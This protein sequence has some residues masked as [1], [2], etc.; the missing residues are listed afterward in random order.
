[1]THPQA[2]GTFDSIGDQATGFDEGASPDRRPASLTAGTVIGGKF[3]IDRL[4]G[5]GGM[6]TVYAAT[7]TLAQSSVALKILSPELTENERSQQRFLQEFRIAQQLSH[8]GVVRAYAVDRHEGQFYY[9]MELV[10][11]PSLRDE[12]RKRKEP[13]A[14]DEAVAIVRGLA[15]A[16]EHAHTITVHR[17]IKPDNVLVAQGGKPKLLDFG[18]AK[19][20]LATDV[21][22]RTSAAMGTAYYMAPEQVRGASDVDARADLYSLGV[23]LYELLTGD[24][25][26]LGALPLTEA[27]P[28][29]PPWIED[30]YRKAVAPRDRRFASARALIDALDARGAGESASSAAAASQAGG[31]G[32]LPGTST[33]PEPRPVAQVPTPLS[34]P[35]RVIGSL[36]KKPWDGRRLP[37]GASLKRPLLV[38]TAGQLHV[39]GPA[40]EMPAGVPDRGVTRSLMRPF[41]ADEHVPVHK[42]RG[43]RHVWRL[44]TWFIL[45]VLMFVGSI[46]LAAIDPLLTVGG[47]AATLIF[48]A[49]WAKTSG[50]DHLILD[51]EGRS[52]A[53][54]KA[55]VVDF[56]ALHRY[57]QFI[58]QV[59]AHIPRRVEGPGAVGSNG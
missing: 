3:R 41:V 57:D 27:R 14:V 56:T 19:A 33:T 7:D 24:V 32:V 48:T 4:L 31:T 50:V 30:V 21:R 47:W 20:L 38:L 39:L 43:A 28:G 2:P 37:S 16:L 26:V 52:V 6:G 11:G 29:L 49:V 44:G 23:L 54:W 59:N 9:T 15:E 45:A 55:S 51:L 58:Q 22:T 17:D 18:I 36:S 8:P 12:L 53:I 35:D 1:M 10:D 5:M 40:A 25:P 42:V 34:D 13:F 46:A